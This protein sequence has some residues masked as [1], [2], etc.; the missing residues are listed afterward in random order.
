MKITAQADALAGALA[1]ANSA[2]RS[3]TKTASPVRIFADGDAVSF[4]CADQHT[5]IVTSASATVN[6]AGECAVPADRL[7]ALVAGLS[8]GE[9]IA[10]NTT[11]NGA[12]IACGSGNYRLPI[13]PLRDLPAAITIDTTTA[14][15]EIGGDDVM[16][17]LEPIFATASE[18]ARFNLS[19]VF[20]HTVDDKLVAVAT[21]GTRLCRVAVSAAEFSLG[22]DLIIPTKVAA[23]LRKIVAHT[24]P[25]FLTLRRSRALIA[26]SGNGFEFTSRLIDAG[27]PNYERVIPP[28]S[29]NVVTCDRAHLVAALAR[30]SAVATHTEPPLLALSWANAGPL[31]VTLARQPGDG[32]DIIAAETTGA[33]R[34]A[35]P[36]GQLAELLGEFGASR[37]INFESGIG[38]LLI[39]GAN[40]KLALIMPW[41]W[42]FCDD[43]P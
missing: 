42:K 4:T 31:N 16:S 2:V 27:Y 29:A 12:Q 1:L 37:I 7:A 21:D 13:I 26:V 22:R 34:F 20:W 18:K 8:A 17:L 9:Q 32:S 11:E 36:L 35:V 30:L 40:N 14:E 15:I 41:A 24:K 33:A 23:T 25:K 43:D 28:P 10:I 6:T 19:G 5:A 38:P 39:N 3:N